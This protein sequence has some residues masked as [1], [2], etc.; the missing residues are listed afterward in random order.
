MIVIWFLRT[1]VTICHYANA[2]KC[3]YSIYK[4]YGSD[5]SYW[6]YDAQACGCD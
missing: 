2:T 5:W 4:D 6:D 3:A 1:F